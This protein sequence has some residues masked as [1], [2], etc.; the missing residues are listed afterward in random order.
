MGDPSQIPHAEAL[1]ALRWLMAMGAEDHVTETPV[2]WLAPRDVRAAAQP[3]GQPLTQP[4]ETRPSPA[5][6]L[7]RG[8]ATAGET[9]MRL[10]AAAS[11]LAALRSAIDG[12]DSALKATASTLVFADGNP[13]APV[14]LV[15][16]APGA[17]EDRQGLP[18][19]GASGQLLDRILAAIGLD[20][21]GCY[22]SN[23]LPWRPPGNR[24]PSPA[25]ITAFL[26]FIKRHIALVQ[27]RFVV[28]LGDT[29]AKAL[30]DERQG[31]TRLRGRWFNLAVTEGTQ[32][33]PALATFH[34]AYL[35][36]NPAHKRLVWQ[37]FLALKAR[38]SEHPGRPG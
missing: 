29:A 9:A 25:E 35:L 32:A 24:K 22:I 8:A 23:I 1:A 30:L 11:D 14:M 19:V 10:A 26:P 7:A 16:E 21:S 4:P 2:D 12:F 33:I 15:G 3:A 34:P 18:F 17:D 28:L 20:R 5:N 6:A 38:L 31:I 36:R 27:P 37:D 13:E